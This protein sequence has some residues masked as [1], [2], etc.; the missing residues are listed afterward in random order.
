MKKYVKNKPSEQFNKNKE[1][2]LIAE[3]EVTEKWKNHKDLHA[4]RKYSDVDDNRRIKKNRNEAT[5]LQDTT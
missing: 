3:N 4:K 5:L 2:R 1:L